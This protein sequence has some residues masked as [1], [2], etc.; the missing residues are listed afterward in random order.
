MSHDMTE[1][2]VLKS[3]FLNTFSKVKVSK[4]HFGRDGMRHMK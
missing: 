1:F 3:D 2:N 4:G